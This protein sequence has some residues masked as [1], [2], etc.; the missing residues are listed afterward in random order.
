MKHPPSL[1]ERLQGLEQ[2]IASPSTCSVGQFIASQDE[3]TQKILLRL[4]DDTFISTRQ[5]Y[6]ELS[7]EEGHPDRAILADH[8]K[9][10]CRC[11][12]NV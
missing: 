12:A 3:E 6:M 7:S 9:K 11:F 2:R 5:L 1:R 4:L 10:K 8:R